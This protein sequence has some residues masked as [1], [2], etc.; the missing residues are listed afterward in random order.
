MQTF[1]DILHS[2]IVS[3]IIGESVWLVSV[4]GRHFTDMCRCPL[5]GVCSERLS[6]N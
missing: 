5:E 6:V 3:P 2:T 1:S 4:L